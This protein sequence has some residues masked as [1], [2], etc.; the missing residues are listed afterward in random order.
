MAKYGPITRSP[1]EDLA[2]SGK[3]S[4]GEAFDGAIKA[5]GDI[6]PQVVIGLD[7]G[8]ENTYLDAVK[9]LK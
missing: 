1:M 9:E 2:I 4:K 5:N 7:L 3:P 6:D 8:T